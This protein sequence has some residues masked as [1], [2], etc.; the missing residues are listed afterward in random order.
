MTGY[1][2]VMPAAIVRG[3]PFNSPVDERG[4][5]LDRTVCPACRNAVTGQGTAEPSYLRDECQACDRTGAV[6]PTCRGARYVARPTRSFGPVDTLACPDCM[7]KRLKDG[8]HEYDE[9]L[10][11][12]RYQRDHH[13]EVEAIMRYREQNSQVA[14]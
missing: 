3:T 14:A 9:T 6:C 10:K 8:E 13:G 12:Y 11:R 7:M 5:P 2:P 4:V 1:Q